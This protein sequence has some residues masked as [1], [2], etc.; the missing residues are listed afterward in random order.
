MSLFASTVTYLAA[1]IVLLADKGGASYG[2]SVAKVVLW[3]LPVLW[4]LSTHYIMISR[5]EHPDW[6]VLDKEALYSRARTLFAIMLGAGEMVVQY[7][8]NHSLP[9][10]K[11]RSRQDHEGIP[12]HSWKCS[13]RCTRRRINHELHRHLRDTNHAIL[14]TPQAPHEDGRSC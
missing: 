12:V 8:P 6:E 4:E 3:C 13:Y 10:H 7:S 9:L 5:R 2:N 11:Y 1:F 14:Q